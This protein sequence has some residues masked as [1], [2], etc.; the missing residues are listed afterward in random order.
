MFQAREKSSKYFFK[1]FLSH[2]RAIPIIQGGVRESCPKK[3]IPNQK[4]QAYFKKTKKS[5]KIGGKWIKNTSKKGY[6]KIPE[7]L[8]LQTMS[9]KKIQTL[10]CKKKK[11]KQEITSGK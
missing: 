3:E 1:A 7:W 4:T 10:A 2:R 9:P 8:F 11:N 6:I 5:R